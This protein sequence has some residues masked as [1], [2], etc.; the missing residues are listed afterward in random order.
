MSHIF[1]KPKLTVQRLVTLAMLIALAIIVSK[2]SLPLIP[3]QLVISLAFIV[4]T[5]IGMIA[6]PFWGFISLALIDVVDNLVGGSGNFIIWWTLMEA[7]QG[8]FYGFFFYGKSLST[9]NKKDWL[10][11]SLATL[12]IMLIGTFTITPLLIQLYFGVP[13]WAQ[14]AAGR[15]LKIFE[16]PIRVILTMVLIP[17]LQKIPEIKRLSRL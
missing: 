8:F 7:I 14:Y 11:V 10:Y 16:I 5:I 13:F 15:W 6:G 3:Q 12:I 1:K 2:F 9:S 4:N 17:A